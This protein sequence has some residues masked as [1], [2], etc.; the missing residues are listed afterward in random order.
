MDGE[1]EIGALMPVAQQRLDLGVERV[2]Q[3]S[4]GHVRRDRVYRSGVRQARV[5]VVTAG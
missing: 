5:A 3:V 1:E 4:A 2:R